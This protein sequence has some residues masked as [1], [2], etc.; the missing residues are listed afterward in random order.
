MCV[1]CVLHCAA[2]VISATSYAGPEVDVWS[3]GVILYALLCGNL[4]F[5]DDNIHNL[6]KKIKSGS[7]YMPSA[8]S[9][10]ARDLISRMLLVDPLARLTIPQ[11]KCVPW[12][13]V[14][15]IVCLTSSLI[16]TCYVLLLELAVFSSMLECLLCS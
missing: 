3:C 6:F 9:D 11:V 4:P 8:L 7:F 12:L 13:N 10:G 5:D 1:V 16:F 14:A 15:C 2:Q